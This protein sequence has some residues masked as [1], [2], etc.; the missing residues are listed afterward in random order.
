MSRGRD[1]WSYLGL[2]RTSK[3]KW[4]VLIYIERGLRVWMRIGGYSW[5]EIDEA[6]TQNV[7]G[8]FISIFSKFFFLNIFKYL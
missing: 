7:I 6:R 3:M 2:V 5:I 1:L 8:F 4:T